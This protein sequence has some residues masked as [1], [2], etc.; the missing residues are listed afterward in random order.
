MLWIQICPLEPSRIESSDPF[1]QLN[2]AHYRNI[3]IFIDFVTRSLN[4][5]QNKLTNPK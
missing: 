1:N 2:G 3:T 5:S 4:S